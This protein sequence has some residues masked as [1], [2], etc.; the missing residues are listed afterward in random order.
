MLNVY[1]LALF[2]YLASAGLAGWLSERLRDSRLMDIPVARSSHEYPRPKGGGL[3]IVS[4]WSV[5]GAALLLTGVLNTPVFLAAIGL[6]AIIGA[7]GF[8]DDLRF[9]SLQ[10]RL[11]TQIVVCIVALGLIGG[12]PPL[13]FGPII[14]DLGWGQQI[15]A[16]LFLVW[17][18]NLYNFMDGIDGLAASEA[19]VVLFPAAAFAALY[20]LNEAAFALPL[21]GACA[22]GGFLAWNFSPARI[23]LGS[24][25]SEFLGFIIAL[26]ALLFAQQNSALFWSIL[27]LAG[28]F[29][30]DAT[31]TL[32]TRLL[33]KENILQPHKTHAYQ[34]LARHLGGHGR[35]TMVYALVGCGWL[36]PWA[37]FAASGIASPPVALCAAYAPLLVGVVGY[38]AWR[39]A[40]ERLT[41]N[42]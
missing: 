5:C 8:L 27:I 25:G 31:V 19:L 15:L 3:A 20:G 32:M 28:A 34:Y 26:L 39:G 16:V 24:V 29:I 41:G 13:T 36:A 7:A 11:A 22:A 35:A 38:R 14:I 33:R 37:S 6:S 42:A 4:V 21:I 40:A 23:F 18:I 30:S 10:F 12:A 2:A 1:G 9:V 17:F